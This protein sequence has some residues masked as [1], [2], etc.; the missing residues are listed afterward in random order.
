M[1]N[2]ARQ[3]FAQVDVLSAAVNQKNNWAF[4]DAWDA[5]YLGTNKAWGEAAE[6]FLNEQWMPNSNVRGPQY[7]FKRSLLLSG[8]AWDVDGDDLMVMTST[9]SGFPQVAFYP[10][11]K[12]S[13]GTKTDTRV[14]FAGG[15]AGK[16][17]VV[18]GQFDG[19][20][21]FD[22]IIYDRNARPIGVRVIA[23]DGTETDI[24]TFNCDLAYEPQWHDQGRGFP[25]I[26]TSLLRWMDL[27]DIDS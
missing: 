6:K 3:L 15:V 20:S 8:I 4:G 25:R 22:G 9:V 14:R 11:T 7:S 10:G 21:I 18:G 26:A 27:Q 19:A 5:H 17:V 12:I 13:S 2:Y 16:E 24:S 23:D 1:V